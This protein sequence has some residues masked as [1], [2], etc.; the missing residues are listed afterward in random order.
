MRVISLV[1]ALMC[2]IPLTGWA[3]HVPV[4]EAR[5]IASR[6]IGQ[7]LRSEASLEVVDSVVGKKGATAYLFGSER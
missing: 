2:C 4:S 6:F 7:G 3:E 5:A 1:S